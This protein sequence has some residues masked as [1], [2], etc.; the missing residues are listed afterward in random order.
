MTKIIVTITPPTPNG[1]LH[2]GHLAGPF[3]SADVFTRVQRQQGNDCVL[4]SYSDDYQ[5]YMI[6]KGL[7]V[8]RDPIEL[9]RENTGKIKSTLAAANIAVDHWMQP[10]DNKY[11]A[12]SAREVFDAAVASG[13]VH[14]RTTDEPY[15][16]QCNRWGY[17][18][19]GR[20]RCNYCGSDSDASQCEECAYPPD[21]ARMEQFSCKLCRTPFEWRPVERS[22]LD[23]ASGVPKLDA[24]FR[25]RA[26]RLPMNRW[27]EEVLQRDQKSGP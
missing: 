20:G 13:R 4:V 12:D 26:I 14:K 24:L 17:E 1:D 11:F 6:R 9:A 19:F 25:H 18:A 21:A 23:V 16:K 8:S 22:Y 3:L 10:F 2:I 15:C 27:A 5:S 7:E